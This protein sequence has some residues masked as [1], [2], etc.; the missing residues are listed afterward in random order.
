MKSVKHILVLSPSLKVN[1]FSNLFF[2]FPLSFY[3]RKLG[4]FG[5]KY[6]GPGRYSIVPLKNVR[7]IL[8]FERGLTRLFSL[9]I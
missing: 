5:C 2:F 8:S 6:F 4:H 1:M 9:E 3:V 7:K